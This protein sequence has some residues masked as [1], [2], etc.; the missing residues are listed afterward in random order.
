[1]SRRRLVGG[2]GFLLSLLL[3]L[4]SAGCGRKDS[5][6]T[7]PAQAMPVKVQTAKPEKVNDTTEYVATLK[8]RDSAV[9]MPQV[10]GQITKIF[11]RSGDRV[12]AGTPLMQI[13]PAKQQAT[14][15]SQED[16]HAA[17]EANL[18]YAEQQYA[19]AKDLSAAGVVSKQEFD[20]AKSALDAAQA[21]VQAPGAPSAGAAS[22]SFIITA[23]RS[24]SSG[25]VGDIP[26]HVGDRVAVT[27]PADD[28]RQAGKPRGLCLC[29]DRARTRA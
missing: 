29:S 8:S 2:P 12:N 16:T 1:M 25:V 10:E 27:H 24:S 4:A 5:K 9:I 28:G 11:V 3:V 7:P 15:K 19:R 20:Q 26:V 23:C 22:S 17:A 13:D 6:A 18:K 14:V 21:Q